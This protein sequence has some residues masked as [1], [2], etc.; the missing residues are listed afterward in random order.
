RFFQQ[1]LNR[2]VGEVFQGKPTTSE[3]TGRQ[4]IPSATPIALPDGKKIGVL[5]FEISLKAI[6]DVIAKYHPSSGGFVFLIDE[7]GEVLAHSAPSPLPD[8]ARIA[9]RRI[10]KALTSNDAKTG[11]LRPSPGSDYF[12][13]M[14]ST[15]RSV[16][17]EN[18]WAVA[19]ALPSAPLDRLSP[20][21]YVLV[22]LVGALIVVLLAWQVARRITRP[23]LDLRDGARR[24]R[25]GDLDL[26]LDI[27]TGDEVEQ[28]A[29]EFN[30]MARELKDLYDSL[31][32]KIERR[33]RE[34]SKAH[35][36]LR[37]LFRKVISA[38]EEE[39]KRL[40][41]ELHDETSQA[42]STLLLNLGMIEK[43]I[44]GDRKD[45]AQ[46]HLRSMREL[47]DQ[48]LDSLQLL[49]HNLRPSL[50]DDLGI[51]AALRWYAQRYR[52]HTGIRV[53]LETKSG[54][55]LP[56]E[57][58]TTLYRIIQ[59]SLT[60]VARHSGA[61]AARVKMICDE[62]VCR[63]AVEDDGHGFDPGELG[64][65]GEGGRGSGF[66][67]VGI[68]ERVLLLGGEM[69]VDSQPGKGTSLRVELPLL[70]EEAVDG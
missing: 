22:P 6:R 47:L 63:L 31:E 53:D 66:G 68:E 41:R 48:T 49:I 16:D 40:A 20:T 67:L 26:H 69:A 65:R 46:A 50:L 13:W 35:K 51:E 23:V 30:A 52:E 61:K 2:P 55:R 3:D 56:A 64:G 25:Q 59:E 8:E 7:Q 32:G 19:Y 62:H 24:I 39:R 9:A 4:V 17:N 43:E 15:L 18:R 70:R 58:E 37:G 42:L 57:A 38:Q 54:K 45:R 34:L 33:T 27:R 1:G 10:K 29:L 21:Q 12:V 14:Q 28:V 60:N 44:A 36:L 5:H 11:L